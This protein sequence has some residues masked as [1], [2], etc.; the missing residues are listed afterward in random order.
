MAFNDPQSVTVGEETISLPRT[1]STGN[2]GAFTSP[3]QRYKLAIQHNGG[4][5]RTDVARLEFSDIV[6][7][8]L[9]PATNYA[10]SAAATLTVNRPLNGFTSEQAE[11]LANALITWLSSSTNV[12]KLV[13]GEI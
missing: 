1:G 13:G 2:S 7:N 3:D 6:Q 8:P 12:E 10:V 5:R 4:N 9:V 11:D